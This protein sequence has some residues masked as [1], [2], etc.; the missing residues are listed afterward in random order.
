MMNSQPSANRPILLD[1]GGT[2][3]KCSDGREVP[4]DSAAGR[5]SIVASF[6]EAVGS[7]SP[8]GV[9]IAIPGPFDYVNG[10]FLMKHK[11]AAV[12]GENFRDVAGLG[13]DVPI[14]YIH[15]VNGAFRGCLELDPS[16]KEGNVA[17]ITLG[18]GLGFTY[19]EN[20]TIVNGEDGSP[21][22][23][24][25]DLPYGDSILE[26]YVS[27]RG[28]R[29]RFKG[30]VFDVKEIADKARRG[31]I[32]AAAAFRNAGSDLAYG[33]LPLLE[34]LGIRKVIFGGQIAKSL[35]LF[36]IDFGDIETGYCKDFSAAVMKGAEAALFDVISA[37]G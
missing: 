7:G 2:F 16:L 20:G 33:A 12:F 13:A 30:G 27:R 8:A 10:I 19:S 25:W 28:I 24:L 4:V 21:K 9:G 18:T 3:I 6:R 17:M 15:D 36:E 35:D 14:G 11:F 37:R 26:D 31:N 23:G 34:K 29:N 5:D 32:D 1:V 22:Y